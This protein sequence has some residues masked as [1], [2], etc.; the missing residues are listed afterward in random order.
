MII[1]TDQFMPDQL[2]T[3]TG[4]PIKLHRP[5]TGFISNAL[6]IPLSGRTSMMNKTILCYLA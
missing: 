3:S 4:M 2:Q 1:S 6:T 5:S